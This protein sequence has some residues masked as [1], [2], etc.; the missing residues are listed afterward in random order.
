MGSNG[1]NQEAFSK[2]A[3]TYRKFAAEGSEL[4]W[5]SETLIR[6]FKGNY[7]PGLKRNYAGQ[8]VLDIGFGNGNNLLFLGSLGLKLSGVE[9]DKDIC[10][11][12]GA[13]LKMV[14]HDADLKV[15]TNKALPFPDK[16]FDFIVSWNVLHY[17]PTEPDIRAAIKEYC[18]VLKPGGR[19]FISTTGPEHKILQDGKTLGGHRYQ[20]G[21]QDDFRK[22]QV[23]FYFDSPN[24]I[25]H[26]FSECFTDVLV[27]RTHDFLMT[28][29]LDW[30]VV[31]GVRP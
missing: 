19:F 20:I 16:S 8:S 4:M 17:E 21:R 30:Y 31:T 27:G 5:P 2:W 22:G 18:R 6:L 14:G 13:K 3:E 24:Y 23:Y 1:E 29:T 7:I 10:E 15:G 11:K 26:Y 9:V 28:E 25:R 12:T